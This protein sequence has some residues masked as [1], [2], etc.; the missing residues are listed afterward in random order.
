MHST[1]K[2][3]FHPTLNAIFVFTAEKKKSFEAERGREAPEK[4]QK[5]MKNSGSGKNDE[6]TTK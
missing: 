2:L 6:I 3:F 4:R 5:M 1:K